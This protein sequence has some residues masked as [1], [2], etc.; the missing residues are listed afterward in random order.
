MLRTALI[1]VIACAAFADATGSP[2]QAG[3]GSLIVN[4]SFEDAPPVRTFVNIAGGASSLKGWQVTGEGVDIVSA[5]YWQASH[6]M[7]S[8]DLDGSARSRTSPPY[9]HGGVA[10]TFSTTSGMRYLVTFDMAGNTAIILRP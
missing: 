3:S 2:Q 9:S 5:V 4:G 10:Q 8:V 1:A 7:R 6:D